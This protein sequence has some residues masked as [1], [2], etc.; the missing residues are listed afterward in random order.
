MSNSSESGSGTS[1]PKL[2]TAGILM[3]VLVAIFGLRTTTGDKQPTAENKAAP[4]LAGAMVLEPAD[5]PV[6]LILRYLR[7]N[8]GVPQATSPGMAKPLVPVASNKETYMPADALRIDHAI[9]A[10]VPDPLQTQFGQWYDQLLE[11]YTE[12]ICDAD[13]TPDRHWL[14]WEQVKPGTNEKPASLN[15]PGVLIY[16]STKKNTVVV[17]FLVG[18]TTNVGVNPAQLKYAIEQ[19]VAINAHKPN[20]KTVRAVG[21]FFTGGQQSWLRTIR[22]SLTDKETSI[23]LVTG[24]ANGLT[25]LGTGWTAEILG[26]DLAPPRVRQSATILPN[27]LLARTAQ[28]YLKK[29]YGESTNRLAILKEANTGFGRSIDNERQLEIRFPMHV[30]RLSALA[31][32]EQRRRD[33]KLG[34]VGNGPNAND[35][36]IVDRYVPFGGG[37]AAAVSE[38]IIG[39][40]MAVVRR[41]GIRYVGL[42]STDPRDAVYLTARLRTECPYTRVYLTDADLAFTV[43]ENKFLMRGA[44]IAS[45]YP[46]YPPNQRWTADGNSDNTRHFFPS[47]VV[48]GCYNALASFVKPANL[49]EYRWPSFMKG[50]GASAVPPVW[51]TTIGETGRFVMLN[52]KPPQFTDD[53]K[54]VPM[55]TGT[56]AEREQRRV[57]P[58]PP[59]LMAPVRLAAIVA[60]ALLAYILWGQLRV[61]AAYDNNPWLRWIPQTSWG[62]YAAPGVNTARPD[63]PAVYLHLALMAAVSGT[64]PLIV[65]VWAT[66][67]LQLG[68]FIE[69]E[70][71]NLACLWTILIALSFGWVICAIGQV[72]YTIAAVR[73]FY[74]RLRARSRQGYAIRVPAHFAMLFATFVSIMIAS[75]I[76]DPNG[77]TDLKRVLFLERAAGLLAGYSMVV[78]AAFL[79]MAFLVY[80]MHALR[81]DWL[82]TIFQLDPPFPKP[83]DDAIAAA[84]DPVVARTLRAIHDTADELMDDLND[85]AGFI[86]RHWRS[87]LVASIALLLASLPMLTRLRSTGEGIWWDLLFLI[88]LMSLVG[89]VAFALLRLLAGWLRLRLIMDRI[90]TLPMAGAFDRLPRSFAK[91]FHASIFDLQERPYHLSIPLLMWQTLRTTCGL[92]A[93]DPDLNPTTRQPADIANALNANAAKLVEDQLRTRWMKRPASDIFGT[94]GAAAP[95][96]DDAERAAETFVAVQAVL[97]ISILFKQLRTLA[98]TCVWT[99]LLLI[100][101]ATT[102]PFQPERLIMYVAVGLAAAAIGVIGYVLVQINRSELVSRI[103]GTNPNTFTPDWSFLWN[104]VALL[105]PFILVAA[106]ASGR[107]R[108]VFEPLLELIR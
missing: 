86:G 35:T 21:P 105:G 40:A 100:L 18:E 88:G 70:G 67:K 82:G 62:Y 78:P 6:N 72:A 9:I 81:R 33:Q 34:L 42:Q 102:Y 53:E 103:A 5:A 27:A 22:E 49:R 63:R 29:H 66:V 50:A 77:D 52:A 87:I 13:Y 59:A 99:V 68:G 12:S 79:A 64:T 11:A 76:D 80:A 98:V 65:V 36:G 45:T 19:V 10:A 16:R 94:G 4:K 91:V 97:F 90:V 30:S 93:A 54:A 20:E 43:P 24:S 47:Q 51:I 85:Y 84:A 95:S 107:L 25:G 60:F 23:E 2:G 89:L 41:E 26:P 15:F 8:S 75:T 96:T 58:P 39:D 74:L 55:V 37:A 69:L 106:Q 83:T 92:P 32:E 7:P 73:D 28:D 3:A 1:G 14:P 38:R 104:N 56:A 108:T 31:A 46:L 17:L 57:G 71:F 48:Q 44:I 101:A 61:L